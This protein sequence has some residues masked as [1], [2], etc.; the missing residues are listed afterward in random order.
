MNYEPRP[1][2]SGPW[3]CLESELASRIARVEY[4]V[5]T[6]ADPGLAWRVF[7]NV[8]LWPKFS[9]LYQSIR[10]QGQ[11]WTPGSRLRVELREPIDAVADRVVTVCMP[12]HRVAWI[13]H[14]RGNTRVSTWIEIAGP[15]MTAQHGKEI[16]VI[17]MAVRGWFDNFRAE[18]DRAA[19][20]QAEDIR[21]MAD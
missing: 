1:P 10:W 7:S 2:R 8:D 13:N 20:A 12:P 19:E 11:P 17:E 21:K 18:C 14:L 5:F 4:A 15:G 16:L 9:D 6:K 3:P